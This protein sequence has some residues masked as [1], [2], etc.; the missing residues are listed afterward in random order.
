MSHKSWAYTLNNY[1]DED[2]AQLKALECNRHRSCKETGENGTPHLQG[3]ITF[4][5]S[6]RL[7][8]LKKLNSKVHWEPVKV[9]E[10]S[11]NYC[12]KGEIII[13]T[14]NAEQGRR[15]DLA[16]AIDHL[17]SGGML[18]VAENTPETFVKCHKGLNALLNTLAKKKYIEQ[19]PEV[20]I[21]WGPSGSGKSKKVR[22]MDPDVYNVP[23][24]INGTI[25]FDGYEGESSILLDDFYGWI[26][27]HTLLQWTDRYKLQ[28]PV[29]GGFVHRQWTKV[30]ITSNEPWTEWYKGVEDTSAFR[31]RIT[32]VIHLQKNNFL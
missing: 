22:E 2:I 9:L 16:I 21:I 18:A 19:A 24:P 31:R 32:Q 28:V 17:N 7:S 5:K 15:S 3:T 10:A 4:T 25:W 23:E 8:A 11:L 14:N 13:D 30:F 27:F 20:Y 6:T 1:N 29:K 12:T 26:K